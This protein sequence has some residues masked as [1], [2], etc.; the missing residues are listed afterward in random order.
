MR[1]SF[2]PVRVNKNRWIPLRTKT[3]EG[4]L[5]ELFLP[6]SAGMIGSDTG[7]TDSACGFGAH[8]LASGK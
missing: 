6:L 1:L 5:D 2:H 4:L 7:W 3:R 8:P